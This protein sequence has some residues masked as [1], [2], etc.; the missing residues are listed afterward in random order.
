MTLF[1]N[2]SRVKRWR[3]LSLK[4]KLIDTPVNAIL[5][6]QTKLM[7]ANKLNFRSAVDC[8]PAKTETV[9]KSSCPK[10]AITNHG[11]TKPVCRLTAA[12]M[13]PKNH[14]QNGVGAAGGL[15]GGSIPPFFFG[16]MI[17][18]SYT[19]SIGCEPFA[20]TPDPH[21]NRTLPKSSGA[22]FHSLES[23]LALLR[24]LQIELSWR[25]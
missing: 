10:Y 16:T 9:L 23:A 2:L 1:V 25:I 18:Q 5:I 24:F 13:C 7:F 6:D 8:L 14:F 3:R 15:R 11:T 20:Q 12:K 19:D 17:R 22:G 4:Y 21:T